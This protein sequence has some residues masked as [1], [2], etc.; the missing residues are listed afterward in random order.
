MADSALP[1]DV[2]QLVFVFDYNGFIRVENPRCAPAATM[3]I[4]HGMSDLTG[5]IIEVNL[6]MLDPS[7]SRVLVVDG[8][9]LSNEAGVSRGPRIGTPDLLLSSL[10]LLRHPSLP[11]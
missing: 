4:R 7:T 6:T 8:T 2:S 3:L 1:R 10:N 9:D 5:R 11:R